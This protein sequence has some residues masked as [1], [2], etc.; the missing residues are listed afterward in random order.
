MKSWCDAWMKGNPS[1]HTYLST[2]SIHVTAVSTSLLTRRS[3]FWE[4]SNDEETQLLSSI[5]VVQSQGQIYF[6]P[7]GILG[8]VNKRFPPIGKKYSASLSWL[9]YLFPPLTPH[10]DQ[11]R[12]DGRHFWTAPC[13]WLR[14]K[15]IFGAIYSNDVAKKY[16]FF[17][18]FFAPMWSYI[19]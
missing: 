16:P 1:I 15:A 6:Q 11:L 19:G 5:F 9:F 12:E 3:L 13:H 17:I 10:F 14:L 18:I 7:I 8:T 4:A 2:S